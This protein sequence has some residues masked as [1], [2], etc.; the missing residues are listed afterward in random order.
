MGAAFPRGA[1]IRCRFP[2]H[3]I[4]GGLQAIPVV[5]IGVILWVISK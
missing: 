1:P 4:I 3:K 5:Y 2:F